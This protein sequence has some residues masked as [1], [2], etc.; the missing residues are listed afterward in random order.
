MKQAAVLIVLL[1]VAT[2]SVPQSPKK[3]G[4]AAKNGAVNTAPASKTKTEKQDTAT[5]P[6]QTIA[7]YNQ[8]SPTDH[9]GANKQSQDATEVERNLTKFTGYL[10]IAG[11]LQ[12]LILAVQAVLFFQQK[13]I[14]GQHKVSLEQLATAASDNAVAAKKSADALVNSERAWVMVDIEWEAASSGRLTNLS[15]IAPDHTQVDQTQV[16]INIICVNRGKSPAWVVERVAKAEISGAFYGPNLSTVNDS[17]IDRRL[18]S[19]GIAGTPEARTEQSIKLYAPGTP[20]N[21]YVLIYGVVKYRD[22]FTP[23]GE[24][25]ETWFG[26]YTLETRI[27]DHLAR[28]SQ[29]E[30]NKYT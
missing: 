28:I 21:K 5:T 19:L 16:Y 23:K 6:S 11:L 14:M 1:C 29:P 3:Q 24:L 17:E 25:R 26:Y 27:K 22:A 30:Y 13:K 20:G 12:V 7:I 9:N 8:P 2:S 18:I 10:V 15:S 4:I